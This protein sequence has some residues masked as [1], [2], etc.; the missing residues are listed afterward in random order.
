MDLGSFFLWNQHAGYLIYT[1]SKLSSR[2]SYNKYLM[3]N[4]QFST[5]AT[6]W[7]NPSPPP[8]LRVWQTLL[9]E[10]RLLAARRESRSS[11]QKQNGTQFAFEKNYIH[12]PLNYARYY[13]LEKLVTKRSKKK[14]NIC[15]VWVFLK[16]C[17]HICS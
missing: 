12:T 1:L 7:Y 8:P 9:R 17:S 11:L 13:T 15:Y 6:L 5:T 3:D 14:A 10:S 16:L 4:Q 2:N